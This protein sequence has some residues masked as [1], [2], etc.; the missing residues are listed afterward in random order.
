MLLQGADQA[1]ASFII[2]SAV[3]VLTSLPSNP[4]YKQKI[5]KLSAVRET[6]A[7]S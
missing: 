2:N 3:S 5:N 6:E 7:R 4:P 1:L